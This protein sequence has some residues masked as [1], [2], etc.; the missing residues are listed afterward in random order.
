MQAHGHWHAAE[1]DAQTARE[2]LPPGRGRAGAA[3]YRLGEIHRLRGEFA[4]AAAAFAHANECGR[5][6]Q[7]GLSLLR[8]AEGDATAAA[9]SIRT[10]LLNTSQRGSRA[11]VLSAAVEILVAVGDVEDARAAAAELVDIAGAVGTPLL[12]AASAHASG[13]VL[14]AE[15]DL[16]AATTSLR[17]ACDTW[18]ELD[19]PYEE[20]QSRLLI[21]TVCERRGDRDGCRLDLDAARRLFA[22]LDARPYLARIDEEL[23]RTAREDRSPG[24]LSERERQVLRLLAAGRTNREIANELFISER[25]VDRH[26]SNIFDKVGV[27]TRTGAAAWAFQHHLV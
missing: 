26:V 16:A 12:A 9:A 2:M 23:E 5:T 17:Q 7:P 19:M 25:T 27:S 10:A 15:G 18:R 20:A 6:P 22:Q 8:L 3:F 21:A 1:Q 4:E 24:S 14:L 11:R 13:A